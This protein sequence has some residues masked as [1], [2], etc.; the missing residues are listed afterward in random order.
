MVRTFLESLCTSDLAQRH[1]IT[2]AKYHNQFLI[3]IFLTT[4]GSSL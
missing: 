1:R 4:P 3:L 2:Q